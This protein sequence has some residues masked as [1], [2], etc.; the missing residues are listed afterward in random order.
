MP[1]DVKSIRLGETGLERLIQWLRTSNQPQ[2]LEAITAKYVEILRSLV[3]EEE[4]R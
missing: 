1:I 2:T 3:V 4:G